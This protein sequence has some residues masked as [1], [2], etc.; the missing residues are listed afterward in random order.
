MNANDLDKATMLTALSTAQS[1]RDGL[2][3][4]DRIREATSRADHKLLYGENIAGG[5]D[6]GDMIALGDIHL[7]GQ[8][9]QQPQAP[10]QGL[11]GLAKAAGVAALLASGGGIGVLGNMALNPVVDKVIDTVP[12]GVDTIEYGLDLGKPEVED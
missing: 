5:E 2:K 9:P 12:V 3:W 4:E 1:I 6:M 10:K 11:S 8:Q 7:G